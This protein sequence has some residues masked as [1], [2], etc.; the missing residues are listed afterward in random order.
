MNCLK[1][2]PKSLVLSPLLF[3]LLLSGC[4]A[5]GALIYKVTPA[6][7]TPA[8]YTPAQE[9]SVI[10]VE[11]SRNPAANEIDC[12]QL[13]RLIADQFRKYKVVPLVDDNALNQ[14]RDRDLK[15]YRA[16]SIAEIGRQVGAKQIFYVDL[17]RSSVEL[18][19]GDQMV[20]GSIQ[21][22]VRVIDVKSGQTLWPTDAAAGWPLGMETPLIEISDKVTESGIRR[23][24]HDA[25]AVRLGQLFH[26]W[27]VDDE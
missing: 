24:M 1:L 9:L 21:S 22:T 13:A 16:M 8:V 26:P 14:L 27:T 11:N 15:A 25:I 5:A 10:V 17:Q 19:A 23:N 18:A 12:Q 3:L 4:S 7:K 6:E 2:S 20:Q